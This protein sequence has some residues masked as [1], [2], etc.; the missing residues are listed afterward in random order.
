MCVCVSMLLIGGFGLCAVHVL[1][2]VVN[3]QPLDSQ[4]RGGHYNEQS[5]ETLSL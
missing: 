5:A 2:V 3:E 4:Q 1:Y